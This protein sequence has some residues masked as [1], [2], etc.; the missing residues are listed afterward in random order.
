MDR[1]WAIMQYCYQP[2]IAIILKWPAILISFIVEKDLKVNW[3]INQPLQQQATQFNSCLPAWM[4]HNKHRKP[5]FY[6]KPPTYSPKIFF[7]KCNTG[8]ILNLT[9]F[10]EQA[11][12]NSTKEIKIYSFKTTFI[13]TQ[14]STAKW[15]MKNCFGDML[16]LQNT[17]M[18][19]S[20][21]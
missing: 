16:L 1:S 11:Q 9:H 14:T 15:D 20:S 8:K 10:L 17:T 5:L 7:Y 13:L 6:W 4:T 21:G 19:Q 18:S 3:S 12:V 2:L